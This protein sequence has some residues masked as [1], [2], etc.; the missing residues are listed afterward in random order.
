MGW[1]GARDVAELPTDPEGIDGAVRLTV[2]NS[3][4]AGIIG[5]AK[6]M[7]G[8]GT[9]AEDPTQSLLVS[10]TDDVGVDVAIA[11]GSDYDRFTATTNALFMQY[12][13]IAATTDVQRD[14]AAYV[15]GTP[16][17]GKTVDAA[18]A[19]TVSARNTGTLDASI[20]SI[21]VGK[22]VNDV[23]RDDAVASLNDALVSA[24]AFA[25]DALTD[26]SVTATGK[27]ARNALT[28]TTSAAVTG[29]TVDTTSGGLTVAASDGTT[30]TAEAG[31]QVLKPLTP[32]ITLTSTESRNELERDVD[33]SVADSTVTLASGGDLLVTAE[34][35]GRLLAHTEAISVKEKTSLLPTSSAKSV[36]ATFA[37]NVILGGVSATID[38][39]DV[40]A[41]DVTVHAINSS[42]VDATTEISA[43][44]VSDTDAL[45]FKFGLS[46]GDWALGA[47][48]AINVIGWDIGNL[49]LEAVNAALGTEFS[50][51]ET[52]LVTV[53]AIVAS[54][55]AATG[56]VSVAADSTTQI[57]ST[58]TNAATAENHG[59]FGAKTAAAGAVLA[60][61]KVSSRVEAFVEDGDATATGSL[62]VT[63]TDAAG[64]HSNVKIVSDSITTTDSGLHFLGKYLDSQVLADFDTEDGVQSVEF[65]TRVRVLHDYAKEQWTT[66]EHDRGAVH[67]F[68]TK[69]FVRSGYVG[70][71]DV[72]TVYLFIGATP[73]LLSPAAQDYS[74]ADWV[75]VAGADDVTYLYMGEGPDSID[76][77]QTDYTDLRFWKPD[78]DTQYVPQ[79]INFDT[80]DSR[81]ISGAIV[82][83]DVRGYADAS[84]A[85]ADVA[86]ADVTVAAVEGATIEANADITAE[87]A[88]GS[89]LTGQGASLAAGG[90]LATNRILSGASAFVE[91]GTLTTTT[92]T[93][94]STPRTRRP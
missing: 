83:N 8:S 84:I 27:T 52:P 65:G 82:L 71:G 4:H 67:A 57:N 19:G 41:D 12:G 7:V 34:E 73:Q 24:A 94:P 31:H 64:V 20:D 76:L 17:T 51:T 86:A 42:F 60:S 25:V 28:G 49:A 61:N 38:S 40:T 9:L 78:A 16:S 37:A 55:I 46:N 74:T 68:V 87:S 56:D 13:R 26:T 70:G 44:G 43:V 92:A 47:S 15:D 72:E 77:G 45:S 48:I 18:G 30:M 14:T 10:A 32:L 1:H 93:S 50:S 5:G 23:S 21:G 62:A 39:S 79:N 2:T 91:G 75:K 63:A 59:L 81:S 69:V 88:G 66:G 53:A 80:S 33:A 90:V 58:V 85:A 22:V 29:T 11:D 54:S 89:T 36:A 6:A 35:D 3:T